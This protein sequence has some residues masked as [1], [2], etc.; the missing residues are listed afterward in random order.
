[1][2]VYGQEPVK[3]DDESARQQHKTQQQVKQPAYQSVEQQKEQSSEQSVEQQGDQ[4]PAEQVKAAKQQGEPPQAT[5]PRLT[6][7]WGIDEKKM[8]FAAFDGRKV[9]DVVGMA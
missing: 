7:K 4:Q 1:M 5:G 3:R 8:A 2:A 9:R 6:S